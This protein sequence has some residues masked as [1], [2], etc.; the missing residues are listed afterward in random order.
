MKFSTSNF[1]AYPLAV[2]YCELFP[3][4]RMLTHL[5][6]RLE[7]KNSKTKRKHK[8]SDPKKKKLWAAHHKA[9]VL[10]QGH[11]EKGLQVALKGSRSRPEKN[12]VKYPGAGAPY[13]IL[14]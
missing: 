9:V 7:K 14:G 3:S 12:W 11:A 8:N 4:A 2:I 5:S 10:G 6:V 1:L 13:Q